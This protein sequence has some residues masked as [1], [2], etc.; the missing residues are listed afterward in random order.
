MIL[1]I[2]RVTLPGFAMGAAVMFL[3]NRK[4]DAATAQARWLKLAVFF[5]IVHV[6]L[7]VAAA[8][9][10]WV[11][12]LL[13]LILAGS[14]LELRLAWG[15][16]A[17]PRPAWLWPAFL[18]LAG[19]AVV[20]AWRLP[21]QAF[22]FLFVVTAGC[23]GF[24]QVVGQ[25]LG[26][27]PLAPRISPGKTVGGFLGGVTAAIA[28]AMLVR[29][30]LPATPRVAAALGMLTAVAGLAGDLAASWVKR[31]AM[32]KDYSA[33]LPGQGGILDRFDSLLGALAIVGA[34]LVALYPA[35]P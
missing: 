10:D 34:V 19:L 5:L 14:V 2:V 11:V 3:S 28:I 8:G 9:R 30:L 24:S 20:N 6:V 35:S 23:D 12:A 16:I 33:A 18:A 4:A 29:D 13:L 31:R 15:R 7:A 1:D 27:R 17:A 21:P 25:W 22:A 32:L 26:R